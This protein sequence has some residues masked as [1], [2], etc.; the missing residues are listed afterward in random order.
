MFTQFL[1]KFIALPVIL[2]TRKL[3]RKIKTVKL[4]GKEPK[5]FPHIREGVADKHASFWGDPSLNIPP[6]RKFLPEFTG[7]YKRQCDPID[8]HL[9]KCK[10][11]NAE[12]KAGWKLEEDPE[13]GKIFKV[14]HHASDDKTLMKTWE[15]IGENSLCSYEIEDNQNYKGIV[16]IPKKISSQSAS[17]SGGLS[18][19][20]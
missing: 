15:V 19:S 16:Q 6:K 18:L 8:V 10:L 4:L 13:T 20:S 12:V 2:L 9:G 3:A 7:I 17:S 11:R 14:K 1:Y 5:V